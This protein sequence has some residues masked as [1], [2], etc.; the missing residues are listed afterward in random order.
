MEKLPARYSIY[1]ESYGEEMGG[2]FDT[3]EHLAEFMAEHKRTPQ[4]DDQRLEMISPLTTDEIYVLNSEYLRALPSATKR[5]DL[6]H[7]IAVKEQDNKHLTYKI[8]HLIIEIEKFM[9][10]LTEEGKQN[11]Q[12]NLA[13]LRADVKK[14][15]VE[16]AAMKKELEEL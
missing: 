10:F 11:F 13:Q 3:L 1:W 7:D 15:D 4:E 5:K 14:T 8:G 6:R 9:P 16:I 12:N 2:E